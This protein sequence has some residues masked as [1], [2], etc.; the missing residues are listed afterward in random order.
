[1]RRSTKNVLKTLTFSLAATTLVGCSNGKNMNQAE[2]VEAV[3]E[4][5][6]VFVETYA[7]NHIDV[8]VGDAKKMY[9]IREKSLHFGGCHVQI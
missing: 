4:E 6:A 1:M 8:L 2:Y 5:K 3:Y 9:E 7:N